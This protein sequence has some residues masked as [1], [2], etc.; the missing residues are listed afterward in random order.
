MSNSSFVWAIKKNIERQKKNQEWTWRRLETLRRPTCWYVFAFRPVILACSDRG[1]WSLRLRA[2]MVQQ[3]HLIL[4]FF[5]LPLYVSYEMGFVYV[6]VVSLKLFMVPLIL[7]TFRPFYKL[8]Y[9][10]CY[11]VIWS[12]VFL[13][14][15]SLVLRMEKVTKEKCFDGFYPSQMN[16]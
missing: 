5:Y 3:W 14:L 12:L 1:I 11:M 2:P 9:L 16:L 13:T 10:V 8:L 15:V 6:S 4:I 7:F